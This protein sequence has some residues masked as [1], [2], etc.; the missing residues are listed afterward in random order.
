MYVSKNIR[1]RETEKGKSLF[2]SEKFLRDEVL[3]EFQRKFSSHRTRTSMQIDEGLYQEC[4]DPNAVENFLNHSCNPNGYINFKDLTYRALR[5]IEPGEELTYN[6]C[7]TEFE[8][9]FQFKCLCGS[10]NCYGYYKG[11]RFLT[12]AQQREL[13]PFISPYLKNKFKKLTAK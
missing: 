2:A 9:P 6:Y 4:D 5:D 12:L 10:K 11:F 3:F 7:T 1:V 8:T 13:V